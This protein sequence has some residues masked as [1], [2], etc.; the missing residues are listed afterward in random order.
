[1]VDIENLTEMNYD[2][3]EEL[4]TAI[5]GIQSPKNNTTNNY[6]ALYVNSLQVLEN[7]RKI[8]QYSTI[9]RLANST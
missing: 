3:M 8:N 9:L 7:S 6:L 4:N 2:F 5:T 1:M